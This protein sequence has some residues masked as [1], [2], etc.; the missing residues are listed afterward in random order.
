MT[1]EKDSTHAKLE[2]LRKRMQLFIKLFGADR[3]LNE[4]ITSSEVKRW[5]AAKKAEYYAARAE[6]MAA[7]DPPNRFKWEW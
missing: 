6:V 5:K 1:L 7:G 2:Q 3:D 4:P